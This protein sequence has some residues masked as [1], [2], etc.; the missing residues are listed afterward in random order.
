MKCHAILGSIILLVLTFTYSMN[1]KLLEDH[2]KLV[3]GTFR[4]L[5]LMTSALEG[6]GVVEKWTKYRVTIPLVQ[7]LLLTS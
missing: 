1:I 7:N 6:K 2:S 4:G 5:T 3:R